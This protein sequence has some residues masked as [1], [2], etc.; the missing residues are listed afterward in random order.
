MLCSW[1]FRNY[2]KTTLRLKKTGMKRYKKAGKML[3]GYFTII[4]HLMFWRSSAPNSSA[5]TTKTS[6]SYYYR[7]NKSKELIGQKYHWPILRKDVEVYFKDCDMYLALKKMRHKPY[8]NLQLILLPTDCWK[9][10]SINFV[11]SFLVSI[12]RKG[13]TYNSVQIFINS[14]IKVINMSWLKFTLM[15]WA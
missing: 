2:S 15:Y 11:I 8:K 14:L 7:V 3:M 5:I 1:K 4:V 9:N 13:K 12:N 10:L 6:L